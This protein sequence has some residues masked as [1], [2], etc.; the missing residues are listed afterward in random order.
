VVPHVRSRTASPH[1]ARQIC[2][3]RSGG[4]PGHGTL[5]RQGGRESVYGYSGVAVYYAQGFTIGAFQVKHDWRDPAKMELIQ[6]AVEYWIQ[7]ARAR[8]D[9]K[10]ITETDV[11]SMNFPGIGA[12]QL[13]REVVLPVIS[14]LPDNV[15]VYELERDHA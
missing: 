11:I 3:S 8:T 15:H 13:D 9:H 14:R 7:F 6:E 4:F 2:G 10:V 5:L 1:L 12:G